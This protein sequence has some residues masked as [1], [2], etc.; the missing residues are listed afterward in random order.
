MLSPLRQWAD[1]VIDTT[2]VGAN[3]LQQQIRQRF[4]SAAA[5]TMLSIMSFG[6]ARGV[7]RNADLV[8]G[9]ASN[10]W[11]EPH[12]FVVG[13]DIGEE[14][15]KVARRVVTSSKAARPRS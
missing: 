13:S 15:T 6:Y 2:D 12:A 1:Q 14:G 3:A 8:F 7:P 4:A 9:N 5:G 10:E 11:R